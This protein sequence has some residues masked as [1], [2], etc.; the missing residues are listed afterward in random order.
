MKQKYNDPFWKGLFLDDL[1]KKFKFKKY[2]ELGIANAE[3]WRN[4]NVEYKKGVDSNVNI[5][6]ENVENLTT[7]EF[8][9]KISKNE[10]YDLV[11]IDACREKNHVKNDFLNSFEHLQSNGIIVF[12]D[13]NSWTEEA[14]QPYSSNGNCYEFW[15]S[16]VNNYSEN[17][18]T[19]CG[20][21]EE[22]DYIGLFFKNDLNVIDKK[23]FDDMTFG[24]EYFCNNREKY[25]YSIHYNIDL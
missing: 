16:L 2:L 1:V 5:K 11:F 22:K 4:V 24:Y 20:L 21:G 3:T 15:I 19:Y 13:I 18:F 17:C 9:E 7:E 10:K 23:L 14:A 12:H 8:F 6:Y 25:L